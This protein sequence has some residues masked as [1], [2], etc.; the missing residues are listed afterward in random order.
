[1]L[2]K[3]YV[4]R[5]SKRNTLC[6]FIIKHWGL[7]DAVPDIDQNGK[8][9]FEQV[10][11]ERLYD[12]LHSVYVQRIAELKCEAMRIEKELHQLYNSEEILN[13][14]IKIPYEKA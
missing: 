12:D 9:N 4:V 1:M 11:M 7:L 8:F 10:D 13:Q 5:E 3:V 6:K 14:L 2:K